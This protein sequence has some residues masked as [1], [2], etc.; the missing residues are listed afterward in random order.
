MLNKWLKYLSTALLAIAMAGCSSDSL[1]QMIPADATGVVSIDV[2]EILKKAKMVDDGKIVLPKTLRQAIDDNDTSPMCIVMSD[3]PQ[4]GIDIDSKAYAFFTVKTFGRVVLASLDDPAKARKTLELR[5]GGDFDKVEGLEC[6][7]VKDNLYALDGKVL[8]IGTVN[9]AMDI[10]R[11]AKA[12]KN[13]LS[14]TSTNISENKTAKEALHNKDAAINAWIQGKGLKAILNK[15]EVYR[16]LSQKMPLIEIFTESDIDAVTFNIDLDAE[17]VDMGAQILAAENSEYAQLLNS[18]MG[19]PD[20][21]VL[22]AIPNSMDYIFTMSVKGDHF[23][24]L[25]QIQQLLGMF[26]KIPYIGR[27]D[28]ASILS[29]V[30]GPFTVGLARD[31]HLEGEWNMVLATRSTD[32]DG[33]VKQISSFANSMGQAPEIYEGEYIYQY[34]NKMIRIGAIDGILYMKML[35]YEQTEGYAYEM[36][37]LRE[38]FDDTMLGIFAQTRNDSV[39]GYFEF[40]LKDIFN[41]SGHFYTNQP[42]TNATLEL[43]RSLCSIKGDGFGNE[44]GDD[45]DFTSF[46]SGAIDKLQPMD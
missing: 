7:Y 26:G 25:K 2:P 40:G 20:D 8:L 41:G 14:K 21:D 42:R 23:V 30:D 32:P 1:E 5:T 36:K 29:T 24:K 31:P 10:N 17:K 3:L 4:M 6:M 39:N 35:D 9:K 11:A 45:N 43:L 18:T 33:V 27:I 22:K 37:P 28:L 16:E 44:D 19:K 15:S 34:D 38:F 46:M 12:A 13:I